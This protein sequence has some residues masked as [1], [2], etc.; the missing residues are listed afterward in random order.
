VRLGIQGEQQHAAG[1]AVE[2]VH[3]PDALA[4]LL[5]EQRPRVLTALASGNDVEA[6][7]LVD[8]DEALVLVQHLEGQR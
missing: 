6:R 1:V 8:G 4:E 5:L 2:A 7:R 3:D